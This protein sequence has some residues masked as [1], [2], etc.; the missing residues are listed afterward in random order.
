MG[1]IDEHDGLFSPEACNLCLDC[2][3]SC[4]RARDR[5]PLPVAAAPQ[6]IPRA[7]IGVTRRMF[8]GAAVSG[9][10]LPVFL[11]ARGTPLRSPHA[12]SALIRPP[13]ALA[14]A[15][16]LDRCVR[17]GECMKVCIGNAPP[18]GA[19]RGR[20]GGHVQP[21]PH[22]AHRLLRVQLHAVRPGLPDRRHPQPGRRGEAEDGHRPRPVR[23]GP[24]PAVGEG[25]PLP[26]LRGA[27]PGVAQG[28][29]PARRDGGQPG[30]AGGDP[31]PALPRGCGSASAAASAS[32]SARCPTTP[33]SA[34]PARAS[35]AI[36]M[37][38]RPS[39][40][41]DRPPG[42]SFRRPSCCNLALVG[43]PAAWTATGT[44]P[45]ATTASANGVWPGPLCAFRPPGRGCSLAPCGRPRRW[46]ATGT[47]PYATTASAN[48]V[49]PGPLCAFRPPGRGCSLAPCGRPR[50][51]D[52]NGHKALCYTA[53]ANG[54]GHKALCY[55]RTKP[56]ATG[57]A[58]PNSLSASPC[59]L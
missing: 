10:T 50:R 22:G 3:E 24:L 59:V 46:T 35:R 45:Y 54:D 41:G 47:R 44:R 37:P 57:C 20:P 36:P 8:L 4:P 18:P 30:R 40:T 34:S 7:P 15:E 21:R 13:G 12:R 31:G 56:D 52:G 19:A 55:N 32:S 27:L 43:V 6:A 28:H 14:E 38:L 33:A 11:R 17:C 16:F 58:R 39:P 9:L 53:S 48:G 2:A 25:H 29:P 42:A 23:Q 1:A 5:V 26:G 49:W 51:L